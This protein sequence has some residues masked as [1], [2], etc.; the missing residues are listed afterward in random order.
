[1][2]NQVITAVK[3]SVLT[4]FTLLIVAGIDGLCVVD[5]RR[6]KSDLEFSDDA[7]LTRIGSL[8]KKAISAS[9]KF[10]HTLKKRNRRRKS[11]S[12]ISS[13][14]IEDI[15]DS[16]EVQAV[17]EFR[18]ALILEELLPEKYDDYHMMLR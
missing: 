18:Q 16:D 15:R 10:K 9:T 5:E 6:E 14:S 4:Y 1:M 2:F 13:I 7:R 12:R 11:G 17:D 8:K 3:L